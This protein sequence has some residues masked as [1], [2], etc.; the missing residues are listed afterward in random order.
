M[1][2]DV[3]GRTVII[4]I[5][6]LIHCT[7]RVSSLS[8][9]HSPSFPHSPHITSVYVSRKTVSTYM[10]PRHRLVKEQKVG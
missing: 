3:V 9:T 5:E 4:I 10:L 8:L 1:E 6:A 7:A 2:F